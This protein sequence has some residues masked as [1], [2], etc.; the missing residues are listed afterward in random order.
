MGRSSGRNVFETV[1]KCLKTF[2][3]FYLAIYLS[4]HR[5][6]IHSSRGPP[7]AA[8]TVVEVAKGR[9]HNVGW[10]DEWRGLNVFETFCNW[11]EYVSYTLSSH[12]RCLDVYYPISFYILLYCQ[13]VGSWA[14]SGQIVSETLLGITC[15]S[16]HSLFWN[17]RHTCC[18]LG[19]HIMVCFA[20]QGDLLDEETDAGYIYIQ[21]MWHNMSKSYE[22]DINKIWKVCESE[23]SHHFRIPPGPLSHFFRFM[24]AGTRVWAPKRR[25]AAP[26]PGPCCRFGAWARILGPK[27]RKKKGN[28][29]K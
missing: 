16:C 21:N 7:K 24:V 19:A 5:Y 27:L 1:A 17:L 9:L 28:N 15:L 22:N 2:H 20:A 29:M 14:L 18:H 12:F 3:C 4:I 10:G 13:G 26:R 23:T 8:R 11:F 25:R 6:G